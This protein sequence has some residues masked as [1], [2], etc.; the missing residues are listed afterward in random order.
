MLRRAAEDYTNVPYT[1]EKDN[2]GW[3]YRTFSDV[4]KESG[5]IASYF[6]KNGI[7]KGDKIAILSE[8]RIAWVTGEY[9]ILKAG[10]ASVPLSIK[11]MPEEILSDHPER[12]RA[13]YVSGSNPLRSYAD[14]TAYEQAFKRLDLL[15][16][17]EMA[18]T[19]TAVLSHYILPSR[20]GYEEQASLPLLPAGQTS[21][22]SL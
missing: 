5:Y 2:S 12:L 19:E 20:S 6:I 7:K 10:A 16:T 18:M 21:G 8:G 17:A 1:Y 13:V 14:T 22:S 3:I 9:G 11:L 15:V 4:E